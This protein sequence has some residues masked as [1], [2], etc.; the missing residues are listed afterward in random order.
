MIVRAGAGYD[1]IDVA[2]CAKNGVYVANCPGKNAHAVAE[3]AMGL[4]LAIDRRIAENV[5]LLKEGKWNKG[6]YANCTGIKGRTIGIVG[7]GSIGLLVAERAKAFE[8]NVIGY[9][10]TPKV[11]L[12]KKMGFE[13]TNDLGYLLANSD[14]VSF[15][16]PGGAATNDWIN[17][18]LLAQMKPNAVLINTSRGSIVNEVD[19]LAHLEA[20]KDFWFGTDVYKG[21][22]SGKEAAFDHPIAKHPRVYGTH[23]IGA[24]T[25]QSESAIGDEACRIIKKFAKTGLVDY[26]SCVNREQECPTLHKMKIRHFN[27]VGVLA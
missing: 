25:K 14:I 26:E 18:D 9:S 3:L 6:A 7:L 12:A 10:R 4:I 24:S 5:Q 17:K 27:K 23:H 19:L 11:E 8:M 13:A 20:N 16:V 21:E 22:P 2:H 15:H 1:T